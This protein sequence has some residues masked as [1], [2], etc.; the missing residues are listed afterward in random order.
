MRP[1][2]TPIGLE[3]ARAARTVSRAFDDALAEAGG[4]LPAWLVLLNLKTRQVSSQRELAEAVGVREAT[5]TH[6]LNAMESQ[7]LVT[8]TRDPGNRRIHVVELTPAGEAPFVRLAGAATAFD[9]RL[10]DGLSDAD[11]DVLATVLGRLAGN[12]AGEHGPAGPWPS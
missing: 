9:R 2:R 3:L 7:G 8:R 12:V 10:R 4:S 11:L 1:A 5:L 6:H